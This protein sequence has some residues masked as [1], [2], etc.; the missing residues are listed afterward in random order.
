MAKAKKKKR[1]FSAHEVA[2]FCDVVN[3]TAINW[4]RQGHLEAYTT[5][6]G[7]YRVYADVLA[8]FMQ[9]QGMR[10]PEEVREILAEQARIE[11]VLIV[12]D[13]QALNDLI[14]QF[15]DKKYPEFK[16]TQAIDGYD[17]GR[18]ILEQRPDVIILDINL[19][20]VD[21]YKL[22]RQ[23]KADE[24]LSRP[25]VIAITG[26]ADADAESRARE[27]GVD[28]F[29]KKPIDLEALPGLIEELAENRSVRPD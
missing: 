10:M 17:A 21:G 5:P 1:V 3:Q 9:N 29:I 28:G 26:M 11:Q 24:N 16:V 20:G 2:N 18:A 25:I 12:D 14:K 7:Q 22:A 4:I 8:K 23:I 13:D 27:A 15:L 19:P 6:G